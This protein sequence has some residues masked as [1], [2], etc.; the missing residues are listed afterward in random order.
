MAFNIYLFLK[1]KKGDAI[2]REE[3]NPAAKTLLDENEIIN[4]KTFVNC[5]SLIIYLPY[6]S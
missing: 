4:Y 2:R 6:T 3:T 1:E 5:S